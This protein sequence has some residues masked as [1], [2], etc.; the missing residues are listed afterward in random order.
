MKKLSH[1]PRDWVIPRDDR[2]SQGLLGLLF[3]STV[4]SAPVGLFAEDAVLMPPNSPVIRFRKQ[5][6]GYWV[7]AVEMWNTDL[8]M[9][10]QQQRYRQR[11]VP[12]RALR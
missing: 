6:D 5:P 12:R 11:P 7:A 4:G 10:E 3:S 9:A 1:D 2:G 8:P